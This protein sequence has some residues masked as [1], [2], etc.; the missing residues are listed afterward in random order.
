MKILITVMSCH[1][2]WNLWN[3]IK[4]NVKKDLIIFSYSPKNENWYDEK[5]RVL[6]LNC[7]DTYECL[8]EKVICMIDQVI[9]I[10]Q[11]K[12]ITHIIKIDDYEA[13]NLTEE[14]IQNL[15]SYK[16]ISKYHYVGQELLQEAG[17]D[18]R[19][20]HYGKVTPECEWD[21]TLY[22]G[23]YVPWMNGGKSYILSRA[24]MVLINHEYNTSNL[25][26]L[27][28]K[29]IYEDLMIAKCLFKHGVVP[30]EINYQITK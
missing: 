14:K 6:Y 30:K 27:Y 1:K 5:E 25:D 20:Y 9:N 12:D 15:Y 11:F 26:I 2:N 8:P 10:P 3:E 21:N 19:K 23:I 29:E 22:R 7:R 24:A 18:A 28:K 17:T 13:V 4:E 16:I